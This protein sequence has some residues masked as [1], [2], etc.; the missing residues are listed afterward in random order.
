MKSM[1]I[2]S[3]YDT[4]PSISQSGVDFKKKLELVSG[5]VGSQGP[6]K[7]KIFTILFKLSLFFMGITLP[8]LDS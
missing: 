8:E 5:L 6:A 3:K 7:P 4:R 1:K 2:S